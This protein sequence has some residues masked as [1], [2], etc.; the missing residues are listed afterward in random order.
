MVRRFIPRGRLRIPVGLRPLGNNNRVRFNIDP[1]FGRD[2]NLGI[3]DQIVIPG[4][5]E[6]QG[7]GIDFPDFN[8]PDVEFVPDPGF[9]FPDRDIPNV[10]PI[11]GI[12]G[13]NS[14]QGDKKRKIKVSQNNLDPLASFYFSKVKYGD[15]NGAKLN[16][17]LQNSPNLRGYDSQNIFNPKVSWSLAPYN[18]RQNAPNTTNPESLLSFVR[19]IGTNQLLTQQYYRSLFYSGNPYIHTEK[20]LVGSEPVFRSMPKEMLDATID[21][22]ERLLSSLSVFVING[23][24]PNI[25]RELSEPQ[26][27]YVRQLNPPALF[28]EEDPEVSFFFD[29]LLQTGADAVFNEGNF[30]QE[31]FDFRTLIRDRVVQNSANINLL[32]IITE[33]LVRVSEDPIS[34]EREKKVV[35][36]LIAEAF[37]NLI[38]P[39]SVIEAVQGQNIFQYTSRYVEFDT[40]YVT[41]R[42]THRFLDGSVADNYSAQVLSNYNYYSKQYEDTIENYD[43]TNLPNIYALDRYIHINSL[44]DKTSTQSRKLQELKTYTTLASSL[45]SYSD[46][47]QFSREQYYNAY[48]DTL[49]RVGDERLSIWSFKNSSIVVPS[50]QIKPNQNFLAPTPMN[51]GLQFS[52]GSVDNFE[53]LL[54]TEDYQIEDFREIVFENIERLPSDQNRVEIRYSTEYIRDIN[55]DLSEVESSY[56]PLSLRR[57]NFQDVVS[58]IFRANSDDELQFNTELN[59]FVMDDDSTILDADT[60]GVVEEL[61]N[62]KAANISASPEN[63]LNTIS[64]KSSP[65]DALGYKIIKSSNNQIVQNFYIGNGDGP[66]TVIYT[67]SQIK[68]GKVYS[69]D[70]YEYR[71]IYG[72]DYSF[73]VFTSFGTRIPT[74]LLNYYFG[75]RR[76]PT[77]RQI[78]SAPNISFDCYTNSRANYDVIE[79]PIYSQDLQENTQSALVSEQI[80]QDIN[81][82]SYP[83]AKVLDYPPTSPILNIFPLVGNNSQVKINANLQSGAHLG[84]QS[85]DIV[86]IGD[87]DEQVNILKE[88][89]DN[90]KNIFL[91][92]GKLEYRNEGLSEIRNIILYRTTSINLEVENYNDLYESFDPEVNPGVSIRRYTTEDND[93]IDA[94]QVLSY[95]IL[96]DISPNINYYYTCI[97]EDVHNN[98]SIPS[99]IYRVRLLLDKGLLIP[100]V[101][102]I[103][104]TGITSKVASKNM[105][106]Y[107]QVEASNI[108]SEPF[109]VFDEEA[110][111]LR[112][113]RSIGQSLGDSVENQSYI[114]RMTSKDTGR[115]FDIKLNFVIRVDGQPINRGT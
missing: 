79:L 72:T 10:R 7:L 27:R 66:R 12:D 54:R 8:I 55:G 36:F 96:E 76:G 64:G 105:S 108:Q 20:P 40:P 91:P 94:T 87:L 103:Q 101:E 69:Y 115:K 82:I 102:L 1:N 112:G 49:E 70:L 22:A 25:I 114:V 18:D 65:S 5:E 59:S 60:L 111:D 2:P 53:A 63:Y 89:Q 71:L 75:L 97:A 110:E 15:R 88:Y 33:L 23:P 92:P 24:V 39:Q 78:Q 38:S 14:N 46:Y 34:R 80:D 45:R 104:P 13:G 86:S 68:Y 93:S 29:N 48:A 19:A 58:P 26:V 98:P 35:R 31:I 90:F 42:D 56:I 100:E 17:P 44:F 74:W 99:V 9:N 51:I 77:Q 37:R 52:R 84:D 32:D 83:L 4:A 6:D 67:D 107:I 61:V 73:D 95:D 3:P 109:E 43:E 50:S 28:A 41:N 81:S 21:T 11:P 47:G 85:L 113:N 16:D 62:N 57:F 106:R 30:A